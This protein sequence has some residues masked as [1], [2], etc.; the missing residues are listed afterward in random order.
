MDTEPTDKRR[1]VVGLG[2]PGRQYVGTRHNVGFEVVA[3]LGRR[4]SLG[5]PVLK[6][7]GAVLDGQ[8]AGVR[9]TMLAPQTYMNRSGESVRKMTD[10]YKA[11]PKDV[12][13]VL[14]D[15]ALEPGRLRLRP[16]G[17]AGGHNGLSDIFRHLGTQ[18]LPRLRLGIGSP[19]G[20]MDSAD[21]VLSRFRSDEIETIELA[22]KTAADAVE[23]WLGGDVQ[24]VMEKYN[25]KPED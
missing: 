13:V 24:Q 25:R 23:D 12:L 9:T 21:Y 17:S 8:I 11:S 5:E 7:G 2:N 19:P 15:M 16:R 1:F 6:F 18:E 22:V 10:F 14:D 3:E 4:W 20:R